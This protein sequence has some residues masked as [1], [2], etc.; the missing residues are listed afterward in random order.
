MD[1]V[2]VV[3]GTDYGTAQVLTFVIPIGTLAAVCFWGFFH[4]SH[5]SSVPDDEMLFKPEDL[6]GRQ[7]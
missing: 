1:V 6:H 7:E 5:T 2:A 3:S 4:R